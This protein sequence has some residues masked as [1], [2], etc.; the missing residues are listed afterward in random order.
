M[1]AVRVR[2]TEG[3]RDLKRKGQEKKM[4]R[5]DGKVE[6]VKFKKKKKKE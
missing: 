5:N 4:P 1:H 6:G 3:G 2:R